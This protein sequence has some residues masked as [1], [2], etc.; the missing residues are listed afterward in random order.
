MVIIP[1][2]GG[3][4]ID[5]MQLVQKS[6]LLE[7]LT[8]VSCPNCPAGTSAVE[9]IRTVFGERIVTNAVHGKFLAQPIS[10]SKY[11][12]RTDDAEDMENF[13]APFI[14]KPVA[15]ID[16][17]SFDG[18]D[19][20]TV[21]N[22]G[23]WQSLVADRLAEIAMVAIELS[24]DYNEAS[25][26]AS[27]NVTITALEDI[28]GNIKLSVLTNES[29]II[30][31]QLNQN[32]IIDMYEHNHVM[33]HMLT[34]ISGDVLISG[35]T[36]GESISKNYSY[37]VPDENDGEWNAD[38]MEVVSFVTSSEFDNEVLQAAAV[39]LN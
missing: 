30:D 35:I 16:R 1:D 32:E 33:R 8:G 9:S 7:E 38:N 27:I 13:L 5:T 11:D 29:H 10:D 19:F 14:G 15:V 22:I 18:Q 6:V 12:F 37:T 25:R 39:H 4:P 23:L 28:P 3:G 20:M 24:S 21:D 31:V 34:S 26:Q 36:E 17:V 2:F